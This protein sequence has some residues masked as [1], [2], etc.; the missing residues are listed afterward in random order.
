MHA[1]VRF[2]L[3]IIVF[4]LT[5]QPCFGECTNPDVDKPHAA[6]PEAECW[7][8]CI[9]EGWEDTC[10]QAASANVMSAECGPCCPFTAQEIYEG[11]VAM[12]GNCGQWPEEE[13]AS[14]LAWLAENCPLCELDI[15]IAH[16]GYEGQ[17][18]VNPENVSFDWADAE[19]AAGEHI[20]IWVVTPAKL[21]LPPRPTGKQVGSH[22]LTYKGREGGRAHIHDSD[23]DIGGTDCDFYDVGAD[24]D[25]DYLED[26]WDEGVHGYLHGVISVSATGPSGAEETTFGTIKALYR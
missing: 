3:V 20:K 25:G 17:P 26:Y 10:T 8:D 15:K 19:I 2:V 22:E 21:S 1:K 6:C 16:N 23:C 5:V 9:D 4:A 12:T 24:A 14:M 13:R 11:I 7:G 18:A